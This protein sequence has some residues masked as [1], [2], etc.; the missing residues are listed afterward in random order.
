[1][2]CQENWERMYCVAVIWSMFVQMERY[3]KSYSIRQ[4]RCHKKERRLCSSVKMVGLW[5]SLR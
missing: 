1:M 5:E 4:R 3:R 2:G